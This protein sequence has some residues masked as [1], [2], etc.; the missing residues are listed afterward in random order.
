MIKAH[1]PVVLSSLHE[2]EM[3]FADMVSVTHHET[4]SISRKTR[5]RPVCT[6][7]QGD[8]AALSHTA[9]VSRFEVDRY[10]SSVN[11]EW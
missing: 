3:V 9:S 2:G 10:L 7:E 4:R 1:S 5:M 8:L 11:R 6:T